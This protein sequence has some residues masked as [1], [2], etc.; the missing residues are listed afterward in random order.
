[1]AV[2]WARITVYV[3]RAVAWGTAAGGGGQMAVLV[4]CYW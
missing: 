4:V 1:M 2:E 3:L